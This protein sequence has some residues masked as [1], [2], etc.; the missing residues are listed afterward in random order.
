MVRG[1]ASFV[2]A[3]RDLPRTDATRMWPSTAG[4]Q[5]TVARILARKLGVG[6]SVRTDQRPV[7]C[8]WS[9]VIPL[10]AVDRNGRTGTGDQGPDS[11]G[12]FF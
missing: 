1:S 8:R 10:C 5:T 6:S 9:L 4:A 12:D 3:G 2:P 11:A 7:D